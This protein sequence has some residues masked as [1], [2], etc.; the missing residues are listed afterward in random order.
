V[1]IQKSPDIQQ[2]WQQFQNRQQ[3]KVWDK[4]PPA[5]VA[6]PLAVHLPTSNPL[7]AHSPPQESVKPYEE[8]RPNTDTSNFFSTSSSEEEEEFGGELTYRSQKLAFMAHEIDI[9]ALSAL[10]PGNDD[11]ETSS[12][13]STGSYSS[14]EREPAAG[15]HPTRVHKEASAELDGYINTLE[16]LGR[17]LTS[18]PSLTSPKSPPE[19]RRGSFSSTEETSSSGDDLSSLS[20][21]VGGINIDFNFS[22]SLR[23]SMKGKVSSSGSGSYSSDSYSSDTPSDDGNGYSLSDLKGLAGDV[24]FDISTSE[25][26]DEDSS[27]DSDSYN[28]EEGEIFFFFFFFETSISGD[29]FPNQKRSL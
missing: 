7:P 16:N 24:S 27:E 11:Y 5:Q 22:T 21:A 25:S 12:Y 14:D 3:R 10:S 9:S 26:S 18:S 4:P 6:A 8:S 29:E 15:R 20:T 17:G 2:Q 19:A 28:H 13:S 23:A 1:P